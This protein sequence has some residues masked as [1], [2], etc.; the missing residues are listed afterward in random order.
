LTLSDAQRRATKLAKLVRHSDYRAALRLRVA[1]A[2]EHDAWSFGASFRTVIDAGANRGQFALFARKA[3]PQATLLCFEPLAGPRDTLTNALGDDPKLR[4]F[5]MALGDQDGE[6][7]LHVSRSDDSSSLLP[8][9]DRQVR[10]FAATDEV[11]VV[12]VPVRRLDSVLS[13]DDLHA[14]T[15]LKIDVQ[16]GELAVL[17]GADA[18][19]G[20]IEEIVVECSFVELYEGQP[21]ADEVLARARD[22]GFRIVDVM[23]SARTATGELLQADFHLA[24]RTVSSLDG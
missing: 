13:Q 15:L 14:P 16:G 17:E 4:L 8:I 21:R 23:P 18:L 5:D 20:S 11:A 9:S 10:A 19:L 12:S 6:A 1:A 24:R 2:V 7:E 3:F 22:A